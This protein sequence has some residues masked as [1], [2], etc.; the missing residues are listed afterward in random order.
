[1]ITVKDLC[2]NIE[3]QG[4]IV[5]RAFNCKDEVIAEIPLEHCVAEWILYSEVKYM[6]VEHVD[7]YNMTDAPAIIIEI[8]EEDD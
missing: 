7:I 5:V 2:D 4:N 6:Y 8:R 3:M 1:M